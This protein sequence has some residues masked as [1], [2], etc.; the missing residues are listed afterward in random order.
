ITDAVLKLY[1]EI[2]DPTISV[3][4]I[5]VTAIDV[6]SRDLA[7]EQE[8]YEQMNLF[9]PAVSQEKEKEDQQERE[10]ENRVQNAIIE[11][12]KKFGKNSVLKGTSL[13]DGATGRERNRQ[14]GGHK[15]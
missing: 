6:I 13:Q 7:K 3:R 5:T 1:D 2:C 10:K 8:S 4:R 14:I 15:A 12:Q 9:A 11:I